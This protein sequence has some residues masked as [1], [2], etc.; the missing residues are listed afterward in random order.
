MGLLTI[1]A[2]VWS[3]QATTVNR[4]LLVN[5]MVIDLY[6]M[7]LRFHSQQPSLVPEELDLTVTEQNCTNAGGSAAG[8]I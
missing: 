4:P 6:F 3:C 2:M 7:Y 8:C 1:I 5:Y